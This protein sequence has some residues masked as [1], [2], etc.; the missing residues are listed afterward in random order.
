MTDEERH[1]TIIIKLNNLKNQ[2]D[3]AHDFLHDNENNESQQISDVNAWMDNVESDLNN[4]NPLYYEARMA[5]IQ[6]ILPE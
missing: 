1:S 4:G 3:R 6:T 2:V 5:E